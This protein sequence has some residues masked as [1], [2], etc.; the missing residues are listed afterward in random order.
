MEVIH[1][2]DG[3]LNNFDA[4]DGLRGVWI[5]LDFLL[6]LRPSGSLGWVRFLRAQRNAGKQNQSCC[7]RIDFMCHETKYGTLPA[8]HKM[9]VL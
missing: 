7:L 8:I 3:V 5:G 4:E 1:R 9:I 2:S 6:R